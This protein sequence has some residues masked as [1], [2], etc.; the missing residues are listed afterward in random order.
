M[1]CTLPD[2]T[3][4]LTDA[5]DSKEEIHYLVIPNNEISRIYEK[6]ILSWFKT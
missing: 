3:G 5:A 6:Q 4:Y 2:M 1:E